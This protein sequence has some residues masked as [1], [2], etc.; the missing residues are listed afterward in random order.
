MGVRSFARSISQGDVPCYVWGFEPGWLDGTPMSEE[1]LKRL[2]PGVPP[3][4]IPGVG[5]GVNANDLAELIVTSLQR[6]HLWHGTMTRIDG[7]DQ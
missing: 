5:E 6:P 3:H 2:P 7:G 1:V 4:R